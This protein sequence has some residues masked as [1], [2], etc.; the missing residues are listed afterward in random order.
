MASIERGDEIFGL[1][2][3]WGGRALALGKL[4][5]FVVVFSACLLG[6]GVG[7]MTALHLTPQA[8]KAMGQSPKALLLNEVSLAAGVVIATVIL[9]L[10]FREPLGR[11]GFGLNQTLGRR[12]RDLGL[13]LVAG[14]VLLTALLAAI[15]ALGGYDFGRITDTPAQAIHYGLLYALLFGLVAVGEE[16]MFRG[17]AL[18]QLSRAISFWPAAVLLSIG[19]GAIHAGNAAETPVGLVSAGAV[20]FVFAY[21]FWRSGS[22]LW[23]LGFH[24]AWD[25][26]QS[27]VWGVADSG[28]VTPGTLF[29]PKFHGPEWLTG[30]SVGPEASWVVVP[31]ILISGVAAHVMLSRPARRA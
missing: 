29:T 6:I 4:L 31:I 18:V 15:A 14:F 30:G 19:F 27:F 9:A 8:V 16:F 28:I 1:A 13:G 26:A 25:Y 12:L 17:Y 22:L 10:I 20:G 7:L 24:A 23:A 3:T 2:P 11:F 5:L 21:S